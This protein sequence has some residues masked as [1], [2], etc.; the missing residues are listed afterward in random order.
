MI[1][2][3]VR[4]IFS[5]IILNTILISFLKAAV[6]RLKIELGFIKISKRASV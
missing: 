4:S 2:S 3:T 6:T 1:R 5:A